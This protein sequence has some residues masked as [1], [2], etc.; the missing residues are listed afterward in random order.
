MP[1]LEEYIEKTRKRLSLMEDHKAKGYY[2]FFKDISE[3][4]YDNNDSRDCLFEYFMANM[5]NFFEQNGVEYEADLSNYINGAYMPSYT[6]IE[7]IVRPIKDSAHVIKGAAGKN[8]ITLGEDGFLDFPALLYGLSA[9]P[10]MRERLT[11]VFGAELISEEIFPNFDRIQRKLE[12]VIKIATAILEKRNID[13]LSDKEIIARIIS[14]DK[15]VHAENEAIEEITKKLKAIEESIQQNG[16]YTLEN[17][18]TYAKLQQQL[19]EHTEARDAIVKQITEKDPSDLRDEMKLSLGVQDYEKM[20]E[21]YK[22]EATVMEGLK[23]KGVSLPEA[24]QAVTKSVSDSQSKLQRMR[25]LKLDIR[26]CRKKLEVLDIFMSSPEFEE[27]YRLKGEK[28]TLELVLADKKTECDKTKATKDSA[29]K[30]KE[31]YD[32]LGIFAKKGEEGKK[33]KEEVERSAGIEEKL[34]KDE[35]ELQTTTELLTKARTAVCN[36]QKRY[37]ELFEKLDQAHGGMLSNALR[38]EFFGAKMIVQGKDEI[39][40]RRENIASALS[41]FEQQLAQQYPETEEEIRDSIEEGKQQIT[42][43]SGMLEQKK[44]GA[45]PDEV[46]LDALETAVDLVNETVTETNEDQD[47]ISSR[48]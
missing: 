32:K 23:S 46:F 25:A 31:R 38:T 3:L 21:T 8:N 16:I 5:A 15:N 39:Q 13:S 2:E 9:F 27:L 29:D 40:T 4:T 1:K 43:L 26:D 24:L 34:K 45:E 6:K 41:S 7:D 11:E 20:H 30:A 44:N 14:D 47:A 18:P 22:Y 36:S 28:T 37:D 35:A 33:L 12:K 19:K 17:H 42:V 48:K 10:E